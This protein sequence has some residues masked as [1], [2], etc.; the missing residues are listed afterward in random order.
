MKYDW[1]VLQETSHW[2]AINKPSGLTVEPVWDY[3]SAEEQVRSYLKE[4]GRREQPYLGI[5]HRLDRPVSGVLLLAKKK[6]SLRFL[7]QQFAERQV[8]KVYWAICSGSPP[9]QNGILEHHL[10]KD[11]REKRS[12]VFPAAHKGTSPA[13]LSYRIIHRETNRTWLE[14]TLHTGRYHQIRA[15]L[16]AIGCPIVGDTKYGSQL[17]DAENSI[18]LHARSLT[19]YDPVSVQEKI[20]CEAPVPY[21]AVWQ[22]Q[23]K[24]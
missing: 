2:L 11:Q 5:V 18:A 17:A 22:K 23:R 4:T 20:T 10:L 3:P 24:I 12:V 9:D 14:V 8:Q 21:R 15:Q 7:N 19:F 1:T 13:K 6:S 16:A